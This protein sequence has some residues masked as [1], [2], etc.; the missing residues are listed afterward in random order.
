M[1]VFVQY[2]ISND[3]ITYANKYIFDTVQYRASIHTDYYS[4][5]TGFLSA[6][7]EQKDNVGVA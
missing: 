1:Y 4:F 2:I 3:N 5:K 7:N 6:V